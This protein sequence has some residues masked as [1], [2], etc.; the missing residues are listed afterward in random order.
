MLHIENLHVYINKTPILKGLNLKILPGEIHVIMG[1]NGSGKSTLA[2]VISGK[3][4]YKITKGNILFNNKNLINYSP[5]QRSQLG[6]FLSFQHPIEIPGISVINFIKTSINEI[7]KSKGL[8]ELPAK[9][10]IIKMRQIAKL[11]KLEKDFFYRSLNDGFSGG[12]KK[13]N[14][15]F[16]MA[17]LNPLLSILDEVDSGLDIDSLRIISNVIKLL[18][19]NTNSIIIITHYK[20]LLD[21]LFSDYIVHVLHNGT[22]VKSGN[23]KLV[24]KLEKQGYDWIKN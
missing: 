1:P 12:E 21:Y 19:T 14:E 10:I 23:N 24:D 11:L 13:K 3:E 5:E 17:M 18:K 22:I 15:I 6:I 9:D 2:S 4:E 16:Q 20:R 8:P 7:R